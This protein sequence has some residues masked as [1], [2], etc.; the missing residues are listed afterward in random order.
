MPT[1]VS[2]WAQLDIQTHEGSRAMHGGTWA[3]P[4][5]ALGRLRC[6]SHGRCLHSGL[7]AVWGRFSGPPR[8]SLRMRK[9]DYTGR[10]VEKPGLKTQV[11][12][13]HCCLL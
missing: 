10:A 3:G 2:S 7:A 5:G 11:L 12:S 9:Q 6:F 1:Q 8:D 13:R 4:H